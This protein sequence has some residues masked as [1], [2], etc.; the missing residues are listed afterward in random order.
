MAH[1][2]DRGDRAIGDGPDHDFL[3]ER[4]QV[5]DR[6]AAARDDHEVGARH[7]TA[8]LDR[9]EAAYRSSDLLRRPLS[10][11][12]HRPDEHMRRETVRQAVEDIANHRPGRRGHHAD[13]PGQERQALLAGAGE[14]PLRLQPQPGLLQQRQ[15]R[16][17]ARQFEAVDHDL[18]FRAAGIGRQL[19]GSDDFQP[20]FGQE[21]QPLRIAAPHDPVDHGLVVLQRAIHVA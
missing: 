17:L 7:R 2:A 16:A 14:Q 20:V 9:R 11:H 13:H 6:S 19:A 18:V 3:V 10:L 21:G 5:L 1:R 4:P 12:Q 15:Q 8:R